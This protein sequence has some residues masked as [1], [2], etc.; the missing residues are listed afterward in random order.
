MSRAGDPAPDNGP[1]NAPIN[2]PGADARMDGRLKSLTLADMDDAQ[3]AL[4]ERMIASKTGQIIG[5]LNAWLRWPPLAERAFAFGDYARHGST[6]EKRI[7]E[8]AILIVARHWNAQ[9]EW[10]VHKVEALKAGLAPA[11]VDAIE[12]R[13]NPVFE[14][15]DEAV[16]YEFL[17]E[18]LGT[19]QVG[20]ATYTRAIACFGEAKL[21]E[22]IAIFGHYN[23][24][25]M[26]L[27]TFRVPVPPGWAEPLKD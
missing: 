26:V 8:L 4:A 21:V 17:S 22:L 16:T 27:N 12:A 3:R 20:D 11:I 23:H 6:H 9:V 2:A 19:K 5:P 14:R 1:V 18:L 13:Q 7:S 10:C 24:V 25:A 15:G